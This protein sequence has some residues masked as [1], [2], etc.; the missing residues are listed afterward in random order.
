[1][2]KKLWFAAFYSIK[3]LALEQSIQLLSHNAVREFCYFLARTEQIRN[4]DKKTVLFDLSY[5][6]KWL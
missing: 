2:S 4:I 5:N 1:M 6:N 3:L